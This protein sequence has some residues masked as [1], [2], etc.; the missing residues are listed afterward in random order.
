[1]SPVTITKLAGGGVR[2]ST[3]HGIKARHTTMGNAKKQERLLNAVEHG[4]KP[5]GKPSMENQ[6]KALKKH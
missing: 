3:P 5:T 1:M 6:I 4:W 2:V